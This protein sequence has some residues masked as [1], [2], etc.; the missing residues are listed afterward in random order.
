MLENLLPA[1]GVRFRSVAEARTLIVRA[2]R[3]N[4]DVAKYRYLG[5]SARKRV[6]DAVILGQGTEC[7]SLIAGAHADEPV[8]PETLR[9]FILEGIRNKA[10]LSR[11]LNEY[12]FLIIPHINP[13]GEVL[14]QE[15]IQRWPDPAAYL[16]HAK[17]EPPGQDI[18]FGFPN[19]RPENGC[20]SKFLMQFPPVRLHISFHGMGFSEGALLL[21]ERTW[22]KRTE[23]LRQK[24]AAF[25]QKEL[26]M[27]L[28]DHDRGGEKGFSYIGPGFW[29]TPSKTG[30]QK[31]FFERGDTATANLFLDSSMDF[32]RRDGNDAL[33]LVTEFPLFLLQ[34]R[35]P[36]APPGVPATYFDFVAKK[37]SFV[38]KLRRGESIA[39]ELEAFRVK[40]VDLQQAIRAQL[41]VLQLGI[42]ALKRA[43]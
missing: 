17:R 38:A 3:K 34:R 1:S 6:V 23:I 10:K 15:W 20:V 36:K 16:L 30:M 4:P 8:G 12:R 39:A 22:I 5:K 29:T 32:A 43:R 40:P 24:F 33:C 19:L 42:E 37:E 18:E 7:I 13:D 41:F 31:Y 21:I 14:N 9:T 27:K 2:C 28:H 26:G 25:V 35:Q 11:L